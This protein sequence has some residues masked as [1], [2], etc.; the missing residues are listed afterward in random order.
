MFIIFLYKFKETLH[1]NIKKNKLWEPIP[2]SLMY[3]YR[4][5]AVSAI[6]TRCTYA[7]E[8]NDSVTQGKCHKNMLKFFSDFKPFKKKRIKKRYHKILYTL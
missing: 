6:T 1:G 5:S 3:Q 2:C 4:I 8:W 7:V